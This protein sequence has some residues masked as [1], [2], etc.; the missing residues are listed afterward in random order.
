MKLSL[1]RFEVENFRGFNGRYVFNLEAGQ[2]NFNQAV[3]Y[4][5]LV[6]N[7]LV[8][9]ENGSG[10]TSLGLA[11]FDVVSHLTDNTPF[12]SHM[13][14][15]FAN[16]SSG[17][18]KASFL[19]AFKYGQG[20]LVYSY[21]K[22]M[23]RN[24]LKETLV[25]NS[26][27]LVEWEYSENGRHFV[28]ATVLGTLNLLLKDD[29]L[30]VIKYIAKN[31]LTGQAQEVADLVSFFEKMLWFRNLDRRCY[32]GIKPGE[33]NIV[34]TMREHN[35]LPQLE[36]FLRT[37]KIT[38]RLDFRENNGVFEIVA[39]F[40]NGQ[41]VNI[42]MIASSGTQTLILYF[43]WSVMAFNKASLVFI[44]EFDA[45]LHFESAAKIIRNLS[46]HTGFQS[47]LTTHN[48]SLLKNDL[49]RPDCCFVMGPTK[50][51]SFAEN[52]DRTI[53]EAH[54]IEKMYVNGLF[55]ET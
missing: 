49:I 8:Y 19:F 35:A 39:I 11:M 14:T 46:E 28:D 47:I 44:D 1:K 45:F 22:G 6:K 3:V 54:N 15:P 41:E 32:A 38:Y 18:G 23:T 17:L 5:G 33:T 31:T 30:S 21:E 7:A 48:V 2:Y 25:V 12:P 29:K 55:N 40:A 20:E 24:L 42:N 34:E 26:R 4:N 27:T 13:I 53:R 36:A 52:S 9:G 16:I 50:I 37:H 51:A 10:K 43:A